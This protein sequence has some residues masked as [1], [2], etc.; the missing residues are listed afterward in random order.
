M[1]ASQ[2]IQTGATMPEMQNILRVWGQRTF[3]D[4]SNVPT[5]VGSVCPNLYASQSIIKEPTLFSGPVNDV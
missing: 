1:I 5:L 4:A 3:S 2:K